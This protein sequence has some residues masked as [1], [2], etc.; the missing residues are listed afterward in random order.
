MIVEQESD[1]NCWVPVKT[2]ELIGNVLSSNFE[3]LMEVKDFGNGLKWWAVIKVYRL[4]GD[5][6]CTNAVF[7]MIRYRR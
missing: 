4:I 1:F 2:F 7:V 5:I 6:L 3:C